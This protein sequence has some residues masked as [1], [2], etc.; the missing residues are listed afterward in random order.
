MKKLLLSTFLLLMCLC[1]GAQTT[2]ETALDLAIGENS[3]NF[4]STGQNTV[5]YKYTAPEG[6]A[7]LL[8]IT[9]DGYDPSIRVTDANGGNVSGMMLQ[10]GTKNIFP[11]NKGQTVTIAVSTDKK[12]ATFTVSLEEVDLEGGKTC[13]N[14]I[15]PEDGKQTFVPYNVDEYYSPMPVYLQYVPK[16][17]GV[18]VLAFSGY[19]SSLTVKNAC[20]AES[21][22]SLSPQYD[23][24]TGNYTAKYTV[25]GGKNYIFAVTSYNPLFATL[26]LTHPQEGSSCDLPFEATLKANKLPKEAGKYWY[27]LITDKSG[28]A[29]IKSEAGL[30][31]G[32]IKT[33]TTCSDYSP[34]ASVTGSMKLRTA[35]TA[36]VPLLICIEKTEATGADE[37]F[38][39][40]IED[41]KAGDSFADPAELKIGE[42][43]VPEYNGEYYYKL[44]V[45]EGSSKMLNIDATKAGITSQSTQVSVY[46]SDNS[47]T[48]I[49]YGQQSVS[50]EV[51]GGKSY[52]VKW[53]LD[54]GTNSFNYTVSLDEIAAGDVAGNP[55][56]AKAGDNELAAGIVKYYVYTATKNGWL[57]IDTDPTIDVT[58]PRDPTSEYTSYYD[59]QKNGTVSRIEATKDTK[60]YIVFKNIADAT[61][62]T[63]SEDDYK[64]GES[65]DNPIEITSETTKLPREVLNTWYVYTAPEDGKLNVKSDIAYETNQQTYTSSTVKVKIGDDVND[66]TKYGGQEGEET[67]FEGNFIV[68]K[69][70]KA[71]IF[72][73]TL[74]AQE[75]KT[76][77]VALGE[78]AQGESST[79]PIPLE[80]KDSVSIPKVDRQAPVWYSVT[81]N[82]GDSVALA[83]APN[84]Y[85]DGFVCKAGDTETQLETTTYTYD[86]Q[87]NATYM[88]IYKNETS[89]TGEY[90]LCITTTYEGGAKAGVTIAR[91]G[92]DGISKVETAGGA[93]TISGNTVSGENLAVYDMAGRI[94]KHEKNAGTITLAKGLYI[95][96]GKK[97]V[98]R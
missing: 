23:N 35:V 21:A 64:Q 32:I 62:F 63:L 59:V 90:L 4:S 37:T 11:I 47:W 9:K 39:I 82:P 31:G 13:D 79:N 80:G 68:S 50:C 89:E 88:L 45:P 30:P 61:T 15:V 5:Y 36:G 58:F 2:P 54:E 67:Y 44:T 6:Q 72:V 65:I 81:L 29:I 49:K 84:S 24:T 18:L 69:G 70:D 98:I 78:L 52:I 22:E 16:E 57:S 75:G 42:N 25:E 87:Y 27:E 85:F 96:N 3:Y 95:V 48:A 55:L 19:T 74:S 66:I 94:V 17:D 40:E 92:S 93:F 97:V 43:T 12:T 33:F 7:Q 91:A 41:A 14:P 20:D 77:T 51:S 28:F 60:Y 73:K 46:S 34:K 1:I 38:D 83:S 86:E 53:K 71:Y 10:N 26:T 76:L 56:E 8:T